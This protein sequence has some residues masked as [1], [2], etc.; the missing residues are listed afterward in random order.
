MMAADDACQAAEFWQKLDAMVAV[1]DTKKKYATARTRV[2]AATAHLEEEQHV[3]AALTK[4][5][6]ATVALIDPPLPTPP[7]APTG[8]ATPSNNDYEASVIANIHVQA[9]GMQNIHSLILV[10]LDHS[11]S[12]CAWWCNNV[13]LTLGRYSLSDHVLLDT[14][15]VGVPAWDQMDNVVKSWI[16]GTISPDL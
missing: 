4:E 2:L 8:H 3:A 9:A 15:Y 5:A 12:K 1:A 11:S 7:P 13:L 6:R 14:T 16:W 10:T